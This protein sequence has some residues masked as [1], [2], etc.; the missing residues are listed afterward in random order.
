MTIY[1]IWMRLS[2]GFFLTILL[3]FSTCSLFDRPLDPSPTEYSAEDANR[4]VKNNLAG[5][6]ITGVA[7]FNGKLYV[8]STLGLMEYEGDKLVRLYKWNSGSWDTVHNLSFDRTNKSLWL[9]HYR[10]AKLFRF[11]GFAWQN[12]D[13]PKKMHDLPFTRDDLSQGFQGFSISGSFWVQGAGQAWRWVPDSNNWE[14]VQMPDVTCE[15]E[16]K[17]NSVA[18]GCFASIAPSRDR[19][20]IIVHSAISG[21]DYGRTPTNAPKPF[22]D[23]VLSLEGN[24]WHEVLPETREGLYTKRVLVGDEFAYIQTHKDLLFRLASER[25]ELIDSL[26]KIEALTVSSNGRLIVSFQNKGIFEFGESWVKLFDSPYIS[27]EDLHV[28]ITES[29][30]SIA[31]SI[32]TNTLK[33]DSDRPPRL[34]I[35]REGELTELPISN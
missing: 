9:N 10:D 1:H 3:S 12:V 2:V 22:P 4:I 29:Q 5:L 23:H 17:Q 15:I 33:K 26:G 14:P 7:F 13:R 20:R 21:R 28:A 25:I 19:F 16:N 11:D 31:L 27:D 34:W 6:G 18:S 8:A 24:N 32:Q 30:G 35:S